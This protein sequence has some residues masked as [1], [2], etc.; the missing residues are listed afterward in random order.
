M[1]LFIPCGG[2]DQPRPSTPPA[3][4]RWEM[5]PLGAISAHWRP[6]AQSPPILGRKPGRETAED[7]DHSE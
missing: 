7:L 1:K 5:V 4:Q 3:R 2:A 6:H